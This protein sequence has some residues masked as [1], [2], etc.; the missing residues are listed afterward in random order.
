MNYKK[1]FNNIK[2]K[3]EFY[4]KLIDLLYEKFYLNLKIKNNNN[5]KVHLLKINRKK[6]SLLKYL[7]NKNNNINL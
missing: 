1:N 2:N 4:N 7:F 5:N 3:K 6:I